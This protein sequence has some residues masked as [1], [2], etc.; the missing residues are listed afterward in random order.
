MTG[1]Y[2]ALILIILAACGSSGDKGPAADSSGSSQAAADPA[3]P[4]RSSRRNPLQWKR[5]AALEADLMRALELS[6]DELCQELGDKRCIRDVHLVPLGGNEPYVAGLMKPS[7]EP[8]ATTPAVVDRVLLSACSKRAALD[9][10]GKPS[11]FT[12]LAF[13]RPLPAAADP[14]VTSTVRTLYQRLLARD[15]APFEIER[16][17]SLAEPD[18]DAEPL[19]TRDF[20]ALACFSIGS[21]TE[22]LFF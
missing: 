18:A 11:V 8:L 2:R 19:S 12:A 16:V 20:A 21:T 17:A 13:D 9:A 15:P 5:A 6:Q 1:V 14:A 4:I 22:F 7:A 10:Q 3:V